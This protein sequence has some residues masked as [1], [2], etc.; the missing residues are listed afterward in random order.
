MKKPLA[1]KLMVD[2]K[3]VRRALALLTGEGIS[4]ED[5]EKRYFSE[6]VEVDLEELVGTNDAFPMI[7]AFVGFMTKEE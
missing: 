3:T 5:M 4:N 6:P 1:L 2:E 7:A